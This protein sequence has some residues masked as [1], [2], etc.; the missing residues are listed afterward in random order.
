[1][2]KC[3]RKCAKRQTRA[4]NYLNHK[5]EMPDAT[6]ELEQIRLKIEQ[7]DDFL[8]QF[9]YAAKNNHIHHLFCYA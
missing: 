8:A 5:L 9:L 3:C 6:T 4:Q 7:K 1:M 2:L